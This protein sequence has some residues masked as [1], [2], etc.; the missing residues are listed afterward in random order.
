MGSPAIATAAFLLELV[1]G[2]PDG[3]Y[4]RVGHPVGW[5]AAPLNVLERTLN[6]PDRGFALRRIAGIGA[7]LAVL[8]PTGL[9]TY[10]L[11]RLIGQTAWSFC[12]RT[13]VVA[14]LLAPRTLRD[15]VTAVALALARDGLEAGRT[16]VSRIVGRDPARLDEQGICRAAIESLAE[17][18]SDGVIAPL[19]W[20]LAGGLTG[21]VLY[22]AINTADSLI[23][24]RNERFEAFGWAAARLDDVVNLPASRLTAVLIA[25]AAALTNPKTGLQAAMVPGATPACTARPTPVGPKRPWQGHLVSRLLDRASMTAAS[26]TIF[27]SEKTAGAPHLQ[28]YASRCAFTIVP[29]SSRFQCWWSAASSTFEN[30]RQPSRHEHN[31]IGHVGYALVEQTCFISE[32]PR[33]RVLRYNSKS[34]FVRH[35]H[36]FRGGI[37]QGR[38]QVFDFCF[39][40]F[41]RQKK[42]RQPQGQAVHQKRVALLGSSNV[43]FDRNWLLDRLPVSSTPS[44]VVSD[45]LFH[46]QVARLRCCEVDKAADGI[47]FC[48]GF[49]APALT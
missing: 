45:T 24:H 2:Y 31:Q 3:L 19:L 35:Q 21:I 23:G 33:Q 34:Y 44:T 46:L 48:Q 36:D 13:V 17:N 1:L 42:V 43:F 8:L 5:I 49:G 47:R 38:A 20:Y 37:T 10:A 41:F 28:I 25:V 40:R 15:H 22:K 29:W 11:D 9:V 30:E 14:V 16:A 12:C 7:L 18:F 26:P 4:R 6:R 39:Q 32:A 27:G